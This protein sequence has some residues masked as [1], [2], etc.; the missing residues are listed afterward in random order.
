MQSETTCRREEF[1]LAVGPASLLVGGVE[2][3]ALGVG[4]AVPGPVLRPEEGSHVVVKVVATDGRLETVLET[5]RA[6]PGTYLYRAPAPSEPGAPIAAP[7]G[8]LVVTPRD[9][10][11]WPPVDAEL[12]LVLDELTPAHGRAPAAAG[13]VALVNGGSDWRA[14][15]AAGEVVRLHLANAAHSR[16]FR[17]RLP[18]ARLKLVGTGAG[19][20]EREGLVDEVFLVPGDRAV[21]DALFE[22]AGE[23][24]LEH[25]LP[26]RSLPL[27]AFAVGPSAGASAARSAF[28]DLRADPSLARY[29]E[30]FAAELERPPDATV[31]TSDV[32]AAR[33][34]R[35][36]AAGP[37]PK[38]RLLDPPTAGRPRQRLVSLE[39]GRLLVVSR[40]GVPVR[41]LAWADAL[42]LRAGEVVDGLVE[43]TEGDVVAIRCR[44][45]ETPQSHGTAVLHVGSRGRARVLRAD[46]TAVPHGDEPDDP[47]DRRP[48]DAG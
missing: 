47:K 45:L 4:G 48:H 39:G 14:S 1:V 46:E 43:A 7:Y 36:S 33:P 23:H 25:R 12:F 31:A 5:R 22:R 13:G 32:S 28:E 15:V 38:L 41:S 37:L 17:L 27:A 30:R 20:V 11:H 34:R 19:R 40:D 18:G 26:G 10:G 8:L 16:A 6:L 21:V 44:E 42:L 35:L 9:P 29:R 3:P 24:R 2:V